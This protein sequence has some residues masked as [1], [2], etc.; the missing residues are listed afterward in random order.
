MRTIQTVVEDDRSNFQKAEE[1]LS[2]LDEA[3]LP[4]RQL[5]NLRTAAITFAVLSVVEQL[6]DMAGSSAFWPVPRT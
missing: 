5:A 6:Q 3:G 1:C 2:K 4:E